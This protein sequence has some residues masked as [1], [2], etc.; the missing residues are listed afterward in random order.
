MTGRTIEFDPNIGGSITI[1]VTDVPWDEVLQQVLA[2]I[3]HP[4]QSAR[5]RGCH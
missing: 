4:H 1:D 3:G 5:S 2:Q